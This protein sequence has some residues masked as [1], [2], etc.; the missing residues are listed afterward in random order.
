MFAFLDKLLSA[1]K[2][3]P[4][5][6][7]RPLGLE[8][9]CGDHLLGRAASRPPGARPELEHLEERT[10][11][12]A[13][14]GYDSTGLMHL[15][16][17]GQ[18]NRPYEADFNANGVLTRGYH[19]TAPSQPWAEVKQITIG[20]SGTGPVQKMHLFGIGMDNR[21]YEQICDPITGQAYTWTLTAPNQPTA[22]VQQL[23]VGHDN[24][25]A[26]N[27]VLLGIGMDGQVYEQASYFGPWGQ[28]WDNWFLT[29]QSGQFQK[30][31]LGYDNLFP[32]G[33]MQLFGV[34]MD[35]TVWQ[36][37][38]GPAGDSASGWLQNQPGGVVKD[39]VVARDNNVSGLPTWSWSFSLFAIGMDNKV[40]EQDFGSL[41]QSRT[42]WQLTAPT[43][44][45]A[46]VQKIEV[47]YN[48]GTNTTG[49]MQVFGIG[50]DG[51]VYGLDLGYGPYGNLAS[52]RWYLTSP[53]QVKDLVVGMDNQFSGWKITQTGGYVSVPHAWP[54]Y[55]DLFGVGLD[56]QVY[57]LPLDTSGH[58]YGASW[59][60][61]APGQV[62]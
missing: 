4:P 40:Y 1:G 18:D 43:Q 17:I 5:S 2:G 41:G 47:G 55:Q 45:T 23:V 49:M 12:A 44:P 52:T 57:D 34:A 14:I 22:A 9:L 20:Y 58:T 28:T 61:T 8:C 59:T 31:A 53:K 36:Q 13:V 26:E 10:V 54:G 50:M 62:K 39:L 21:V 6:R 51:N 15:F 32:Y 24:T 37:S 38:F 25:P 7:Q 29:R 33:N 19:L 60:L 42:N 27:I 16:A 11:P 30:L 35:G 48:Y 56:N 3:V 46:A